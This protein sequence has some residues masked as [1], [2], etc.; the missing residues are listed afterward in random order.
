[1]ASRLHLRPATRARD[2]AYLANHVLVPFGNAPS[3]TS[4]RRRYR[5]GSQFLAEG[6]GLAPRTVRECYRV[7]ASM[8][9]EAVDSKLL[10]E[11]PCRG[12][13]LPRIPTGEKRFPSAGD[14]SRL[15]GCIDPRYRAF[16]YAGSYLGLRWGSSP[17]SS[18]PT[19]ISEQSAFALSVRSS[20]PATVPL[21]RDQDLYDAAHPVAAGFL[22]RHPVRSPRARRPLRV[23]LPGAQ[24]RV[25]QLPQLENSL[26]EPWRTAGRPVAFHSSRDAAHLRRPPDRSRRPSPWDSALRRS[27]RHPHDDE[28]VWTSLSQPRRRARSCA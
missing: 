16:V 23:R 10:A 22:G 24:R 2:V 15:A 14:V 11:S 4:A 12:I 1:M 7:L 21:R 27:R 13:S 19:S 3:V 5:P 28:H 25:S 9:R 18:G 17:V 8:M 20:A 26:L 6:K